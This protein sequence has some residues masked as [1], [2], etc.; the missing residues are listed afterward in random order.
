MQPADRNMSIRTTA[1]FTVRV[2][3]N[4]TE[5][6]GVTLSMSF[7]PQFLEVVD[8]A[9]NPAGQIQPHP[10]TLLTGVPSVNQVDSTNGTILFTVGSAAPVSSNFNL[11][12]VTFRAKDT[13]TPA[14]VPTKVVFVV[15][16]DDETRVSNST[17]TLLLNNTSDYTGTRISIDELVVEIVMLSATTREVTGQAEPERISQGST[18]DFT[19]RVLTHG[20]AVTAITL[21]MSFDPQ[22]L[23]VVDAS[24]LALGLQIEPILDPNSPFHPLIPGSFTPDNIG[25]NIN[26]TILYTVGNV[27]PVSGSFDLAK[28]TFRAKETDT[29]V[30]SPTEVLFLVS[31]SEETQVS[32]SGKL[33]LKNRQPFT[34]AFIS[35]EGS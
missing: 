4:D 11:A 10:D 25:D 13:A 18:V 3:T 14:G 12:N 28:I 30:G 21:S 22:F 32:K 24:P 20:V 26:G 19:V 34:G 15:R 8:K 5:V 7:N 2:L 16:D 35:I 1:D 27:N 9:G 6:T 31:G 23:E 29:G 33:L 17:S